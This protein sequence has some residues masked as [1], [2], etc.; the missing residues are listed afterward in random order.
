MFILF[1][2]GLFIELFSSLDAKA[3]F[4]FHMSW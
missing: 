3:S 1:G 4:V 2:R